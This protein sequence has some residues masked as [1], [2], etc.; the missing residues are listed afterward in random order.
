MRITILTI[1]IVAILIVGAVIYGFGRK[2]G[3]NSNIGVSPSPTPARAEIIFPKSGDTLTSGN[4]YTL[5]WQGVG[6]GTT[7]IFLVDTDLE[8]QGESVAIVDRI[9][10]VK[11]TGSY[12]YSVP[13]TVK[14]G[15]YKF[16]IGNLTSGIFKIE[17]GTSLNYCSSQNLKA[18]ITTEGAAGNIYGTLTLKNVSNKNC[19]IIG[20]NFLDASYSA[21][22]LTTAHQG[23]EGEALILLEP[24]KAVY[25]E[26]HYPNGPQC[27]SGITQ[28]SVVFS[29]KI[30]PS[31][32]VDFADQNGSISQKVTV[33]NS[34]TE[35][36]N[37][38]LWS[39]SK[40]PPGK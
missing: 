39:I 29:Y 15:N 20:K 14:P 32:E 22:N 19:S 33:C 21:E 8:S 34:V 2:P 7:Q 6:N 38:D 10:N 30:S 37:I 28:A 12:D 31:D 27:S 36:T 26:I 9:Y 35:K 3:Q 18:T 16:E 23:S 25:S 24:G 1:F 13:S 5:K 17:S 40:S 11:N 4:K